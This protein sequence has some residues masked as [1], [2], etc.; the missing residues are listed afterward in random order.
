MPNA[1]CETPRK[2]ELDVIRALLRTMLENDASD[3]H[4]T[5]N[6][7]PFIRVNGELACLGGD[8]LCAADLESVLLPLLSER[9]RNVLEE[10]SSVDL[11]YTY[12]ADHRFRVNIFYQRGAL[13][14]VFR[15]LPSLKLTLGALGMP[16]GIDSFS[17]LKDGLVLVT[18]PTGSGKSTTLAAIIDKIN[19]NKSCHIITIEDPVEF[20][21]SNI[22]SLVTQRELFTDV[23]SFSLALRDALREDPDVILVGE[24]RDLDTMR[25]AIMAAETGHL[26]FSTLHSRDAISSLTRM[27][28]VFSI[29]EQAQIR[30]QLSATLK[31]VVSQRLLKHM[32]GESRVAAVEVMKVTSAISNLI[33]SG[34]LERIYSAIETGGRLGMQTMELSLADLYREGKID[35]DSALRMAKNE[36]IILPRLER[37]DA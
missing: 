30:H 18:G 23:P 25:T 12:D 36:S 34:K 19:R 3:L 29:E 4:L 26:V 22:R 31:G 32:N 11:A 10:K 15:K 9:Q 33:R 28:G 35:R 24:M 27:I 1:H 21:H 13:A 5:L 17:E 37:I 2:A 20:V 6:F 7:A 8:A 16:S 14:A